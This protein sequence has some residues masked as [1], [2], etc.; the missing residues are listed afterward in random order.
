M[1]VNDLANIEKQIAQFKFEKQKAVDE[2]E[3]ARAE[4]QELAS[5]YN[6]LDNEKSRLYEILSLHKD[7]KLI[8]DEESKKM[9]L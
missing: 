4:I 1:L 9:I 2:I 3:K 5:E 6:R 7:E 8:A